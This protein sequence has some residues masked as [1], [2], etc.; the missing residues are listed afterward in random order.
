MN[1]HI[2]KSEGLVP[3]SVSYSFTNV[4]RHSVQIY[5]LLEEYETD[6]K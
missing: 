1:K 2:V 3:L 5:L 6:K 4:N